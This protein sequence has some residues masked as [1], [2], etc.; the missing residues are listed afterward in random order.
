MDIKYENLRWPQIEQLAKKDGMIIIPI[1]ACEEHGKHLPV[2]TDTEIAYRI[3]LGSAEKVRENIPIAVTP[4]VWFGYTVSKLK[5]WPGTITIRPKVLID[6]LYDMC[7]SIID[8]G[9]TKI[10]IFNGHG[11]NPGVLDVAVRSIGDDFDVYPGVVNVFSLYEKKLIDKWRK[12]KEGGIGHAG[13]IETSFMLYLTDLV[14][15]SV[16]DDTDIMKTKLKYCPVDGV[17]DRK[18]MLYLS[19]WHLEESIYGGAG[20]PTSATREFGK[21]LYIDCVEKLTDIIREFYDI[22]LKLQKKEERK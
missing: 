1:G 20:D 14:D 18:K 17:P 19:T 4:S 22:Q 9:I 3:S 7:R 10:L 13:E 5:K 12:S 2:I 6:L 21:E 15:M 11:N 8:S 16:A